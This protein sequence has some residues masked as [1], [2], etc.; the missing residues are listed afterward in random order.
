MKTRSGAR[1]SKVLRHAPD[2]VQ[3]ASWADDRIDPQ[4]KLRLKKLYS[5]NLNPA[6][7]RRE[8]TPAGNTNL[9]TLSDTRKKIVSLRKKRETFGLD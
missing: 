5:D 1:V 3:A 7:L 9:S 8:I 6:A 2:A 4:I